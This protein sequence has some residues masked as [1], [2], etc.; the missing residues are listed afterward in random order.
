MH[1]NYLDSRA[2]LMGLAGKTVITMEELNAL[3]NATL[4][5][6]VPRDII[7]SFIRFIDTL[8]RSYAI[9][10]SDRR[11]NE[12]LK[13]MQGSAVLA[14]RHTVGLDDFKNLLYVL[15]EKEDQLPQIES[16]LT[17]VV[18]PYDEQFAKLKASFEQIKDTIDKAD[19]E[20][21]Q[22]RKAMSSKTAIARIVGR[23]NKL[24]NEASRNGRDTKEY[25]NLRD[26]IV[27]YNDDV[28]NTS[29]NNNF[30]I[31]NT[32]SIGNIDNDGNDDDMI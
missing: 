8:N 23:I 21:D 2:G 11:L 3:Q 16:E 5:V 31:N 27:K 14:G 6:K 24:V 17:R 4:H 25:E 28:I 9:K 12:C 7:N 29:F 26:F 1:S 19:D 22:L 30:P 18:N 10:V 15:W 32:T 20:K 13:V